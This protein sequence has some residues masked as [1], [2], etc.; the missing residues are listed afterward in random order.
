MDCAHSFGHAI[1]IPP[2]LHD[3]PFDQWTCR[4]KVFI[5][6]IDFDLW[7]I[8]DDSYL[9]PTKAKSKWNKKEKKLYS[10][11]VRLLDILLKSIDPNISNNFVSFDS[12]YSLWRYI[13]AHHKEMKEGV[14]APAKE[15]KSSTTQLSTSSSH[16]RPLGVSPSVVS[17]SDSYSDISIDEL[18]NCSQKLLHAYNKLHKEHVNLKTDHDAL[19]VKFEDVSKEKMI[20]MQENEKLKFDHDNLT[21]RFDAI[22][23]VRDNTMH[24]LE[25]IRDKLD[26]LQFCYDALSSTINENENA[27]LECEI[28]RNE[29]ASFKE[30]YV[31]SSSNNDVLFRNEFKNI[32]DRMDCLNSILVDCVHKHKYLT[33]LGSKKNAFISKKPTHHAYLCT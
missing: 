27:M 17:D 3:L 30:K 4:I 5:R 19:V 32:N 6:T 11:N 31:C 13:E 29:L 2:C 20:I 15:K 33:D 23:R 24:E 1:D 25:E 8:I 9:V 7:N 14:L 26:N 18:A 22:C 21:S 16:D 12:A 10:M 28:A